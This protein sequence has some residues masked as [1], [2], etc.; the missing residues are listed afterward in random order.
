MITRYATPVFST[1][2]FDQ[3]FD[4]KNSLPIDAEG[5]IPALRMILL[6][7]TPVQR[8]EEKEGATEIILSDCPKKKC[9]VDSRFLTSCYAM[10]RKTLPKSEQIIEQLYERIGTPYL[11]GG[12]YSK[13]IE[14]ISQYYP[15]PLDISSEM[16]RMWHF[17]GVDS[18]G[19]IYETAE[20]Q[21]PRFIEGLVHLGFPIP[22]LNK[23]LEEISRQLKPLDLLICEGTLSIVLDHNHV[24]TC[25][26]EV[27]MLDLRTTLWRLMQKKGL[28][29]R[30]W[31][32][33]LLC[34][35]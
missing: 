27:V 15:P 30:R 2:E 24:I 20:G 5:R 13:G 12:N 1:W 8:V 26:D 14:E 23:S 29:I 17:Q 25:T 34:L 10:Q 22:S 9:Y 35:S 31:H 6:P 19:L 33:N 32:P 3:I 16:K 7:N 4:Q 11:Y 18:P 28:I 21:V